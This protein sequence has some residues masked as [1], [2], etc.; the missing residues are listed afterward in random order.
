MSERFEI[1][2][3]TFG[4]VTLAPDGTIKSQAGALRDVIEEAALADELGL[5]AFGVGE[6]SSASHASISSTAPAR[7][8]TLT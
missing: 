3:D 2:L 1:G 4:D 7:C 6:P 5:D 8:R